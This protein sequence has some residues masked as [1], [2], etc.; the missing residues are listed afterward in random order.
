MRSLTAIVCQHMT[1]IGFVTLQQDEVHSVC[2][3]TCRPALSIAS[4]KHADQSRGLHVRGW[5]AKERGLW[6]ERAVRS[7]RHQPATPACRRKQ[8]QHER[9]AAAGVLS[10]DQ[11]SPANILF[12]N[13]AGTQRFPTCSSY[14]GIELSVDAV[15]LQIY[16][17]R[18]DIPCNPGLMQ[19]TS[20][21]VH[22]GR[23]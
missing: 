1:L 17:R 20:L 12:G 7:S 15:A 4:S 16:P 3:D 23:S 14:A 8:R 2:F 18:C 5:W 6:Q 21:E 9:P 22:M 19:S 13:T 10:N 11:L